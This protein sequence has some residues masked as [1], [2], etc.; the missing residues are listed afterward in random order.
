MSLPILN[1]KLYAVFDGSAMQSVW[2]NKSISFYPFVV[3][4]AKRQLE[5]PPEY[6]KKIVGTTFVD[7]F[8]SAIHGGLS[9]QHVQAMNIAAL[10]SFGTVLEQTTVEKPL[11]ISNFYLWVRNKV[12]EATADALYG[13]ENPLRKQPDLTN[14]LWWVKTQSI[15]CPGD[16]CDS[17]G[18]SSKFREFEAGLPILLLGLWPHIFARATIRARNRLQKALSEYYGK[19]LDQSESAAGIV[20]ARAGV[21]RKWGWEPTVVGTFEVAL[22]HAATT[23]TGPFAFWFAT[24]L[25]SRPEL[26]EEL[27]SEAMGVIKRGPDGVVTLAIDALS[28]KAPLLTSCYHETMRLFNK[29]IGARQVME[30]T[31]ILD[32]NGNSYLLKKGV[33]VQMPTA[34]MMA[35]P[36][37][38]GDDVEE[39]NPTRFMDGKQQSK[40]RSKAQKL[41]YAPFGGGKHLCPGRNFAYVESLGF[42]V[43]L[44]LGFDVEPLKGTWSTCKLPEVGPVPMAAGIC[45]PTKEGEGF[46]VR[47]KRRQGWENTRWEYSYTSEVEVNWQ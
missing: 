5:Y 15:P 20:R 18:Y 26:V 11:E 29:S 16:R 43:T 37:V 31:T 46:G 21:L 8:F 3:K 9:A 30:D 33:D 22:L 7:E 44:L 28:T 47:I 17:N 1:G 23:N 36:D 45:K 42:A 19:D 6:D 34:P 14:D 24:Y 38:W 10:N 40:E 27:R 35:N 39:F 41:A 12:S 2:R 25:V 32:G 13:P 4:F